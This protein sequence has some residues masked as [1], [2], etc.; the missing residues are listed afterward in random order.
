MLIYLFDFFPYRSQ[1]F[2]SQQPAVSQPGSAFGGG[3]TPANNQNGSG[4]GGSV[5]GG[6]GGGL[7]SGLGGKPSAENANK[8]VFGTGTF[9][10]PSGQ[11]NT[12]MSYENRTF[13]DTLVFTVRVQRTFNNITI[14]I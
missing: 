2:G 9:G 10:T 14:T 6:G 1:V 5:F 7:F 4:G 11:Q 12:G 13:Y 3:S 8:N